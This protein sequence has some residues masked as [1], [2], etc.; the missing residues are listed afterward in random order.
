MYGAL[1]V[2]G[3]RKGRQ[4]RPRLAIAAVSA[5]A[6]T[7]SLVACTKTT[8]SKGGSNKASTAS[9]SIDNDPAHSKGP[10]PAVAGA[11]K[12][13]TVYVLAETDFDF[14]DP[15]RTY[16]VNAM[17][18]QLEFSR[19]LT[20]FKQTA[21]GKLTLVGDL[22]TDP[23]KDVKGDC[24][25]WKYTLKSGLKYDDGK[26][27][28][29]ADLAYGIARSFSPDL[30][31]GPH[32]FAQW[33]ANDQDYNKD[34]KGPYNGGADIPPGVTLQGKYG[35][36]FTFK[37]PHCDTPYAA[38][39]SQI[40][41]VPKSAETTPPTNY[42]NKPISTGPYK[43]AQYIHNTKLTLVRNP[44][45]DAKSDPVR[46]NYPDG[47]E[48]DFGVDPTKQAE[49]TIA[50]NGNDK[51]ASM[52]QN[53]P[54]ALLQQV[55][56]NQAVLKRSS[57]GPTPFVYYLAINTQRVTDLNERKALEYAI[58]RTGV[59]QVYGG[60]PAGDP[61][62]TMLSPTVAGY[63]KFDLYP[64]GANG[65]VAKAKQLLG[66]KHPK[67]T[68]GYRNSE[69][70]QKLGPK[71]DAI[72]TAAG[73]DVTTSPVDGAHYFSSIGKKNNPWDIY[74]SD[75]AADWP[76]GFAVLPVLFDGRTIEAEGNNDTSYLNDPD[77]NKM[78]D[79]LSALPE[80]ESSKQWADLDKLIMQ[81]AS[82]IPLFYANG[83]GVNGSKLGGVILSGVIGTTVY[84]QA[85]V[86]K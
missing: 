65:D 18:A 40:T 83:I 76:T 45:W 77:V 64:A 82:V 60:P 7:V 56:G 75:W 62:T 71:L 20:A 31:E 63:K 43:I 12:G 1:A 2:T 41:P 78:I 61:A 39:M 66:G 37:A 27:I 58:D 69:S 70:G 42:T 67:I 47:F 8:D 25:V 86:K 19:S 81:K 4:M 33:L 30:S 48:W 14:L 17:A 84:S 57:T 3:Y 32:Y 79:K 49:R 52:Q 74:L 46:N 23:G 36:T 44:Y 54:Q 15:T 85:Y 28:T 22:A 68:V 6:I 5:L 53:V 16:T 72:F 21:G 24:K 26:E 51:F 59:L 73:F 11:T 9:G 55:E 34:Y 80:S 50:D 35:I 38:Q 13:G 29:S 10:A